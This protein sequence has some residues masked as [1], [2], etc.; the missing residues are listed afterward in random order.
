MSCETWL[1]IAGR[2]LF[3]LFVFRFF[4]CEVRIE[5]EIAYVRTVTEI[6]CLCTRNFCSKRD[7]RRQYESS[8]GFHSTYLVSRVYTNRC[9]ERVYK[10]R[11]RVRVYARVLQ[12]SVK[13]T[14]DENSRPTL[15]A[16]GDGKHLFAYIVFF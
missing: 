12:T 14:I 7:P 6:G 9:V 2:V 8:F 13:T 11:V 1:R 16:L 5:R 4:I 15:H 3:Y 10:Y